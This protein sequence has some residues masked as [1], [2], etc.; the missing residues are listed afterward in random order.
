MWKIED[1]ESSD[2]LTRKLEVAWD[3]SS[4]KFEIIQFYQ[5]DELVKQ[6]MIFLKNL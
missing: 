4:R 1:S 6:K 3:K 5:K 2:F